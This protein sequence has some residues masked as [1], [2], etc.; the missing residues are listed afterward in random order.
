MGILPSPSTTQSTPLTTKRKSNQLDFSNLTPLS[1][2]SK[3]VKNF[4]G[5][6]DPA[7]PSPS[8]RRKLFGKQKETDAMDS[9]AEDEEDSPKRI[10]QEDDD[11]ADVKPALLTAED[12]ARTGELTE[13][14][15]KIKLKRQAS[16]EPLAAPPTSARRSDSPTSPG[17]IGL[18]LGTASSS[19]PAST[20]MDTPNS[21]RQASPDANPN[22]RARASLPGIDNALALT[23]G[24][25]SKSDVIPDSQKQQG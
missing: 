7:A 12:A 4:A 20:V 22:K 10:K 24:V 8:A 9:D 19:A 6:R 1:S 25:E 17:S 3:G 23:P 18:F 21:N 16:A 14:V 13:G 2:S 5:Y 15:R 11:D